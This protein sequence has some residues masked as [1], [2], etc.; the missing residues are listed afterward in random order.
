MSGKTPPRDDPQIIDAAVLM[1][2]VPG[3]VAF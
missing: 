1:E 3:P 2:N